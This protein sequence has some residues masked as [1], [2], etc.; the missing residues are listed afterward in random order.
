MVILLAIIGIMLCRSRNG[1]K[2]DK[3][4]EEE[5]AID[6]IPPAENDPADAL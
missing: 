5:A 2:N 1:Q 6:E 4:P 3:I